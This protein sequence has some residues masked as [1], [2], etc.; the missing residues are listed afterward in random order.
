MKQVTCYQ[1]GQI[2]HWAKHCPNISQDVQKVMQIA[3]EREQPVDHGQFSAKSTS[4][5]FTYIEL[6][7]GIGGFRIALDKLGGHCVF[8]SEID[9][10]CVINYQKNFGDRPAGDITRIASDCIPDHDILVGGFPCQPF[11]NSGKLEGMNDTKGVLFREIARILKDKQPKGFILENVRGLLLHNDGDT[12]ATIRKELE[13][14]GYT[15]QWDII[16][17]VNLLPQERKRLYIIGIRRDPEESQRR[18]IFPTLPNLNRGVRDIMQQPSEKYPLS[19]DE[20]EKLTLT[21]HQLSKVLAQTYTQKF[22]EARFLCDLSL[23]SKTL[24]SSYSSYMV[25]SQFIPVYSGSQ[26]GRVQISYNDESM[27]WRRFSPREAARLQGFPESFYL[28]PQRSYHMIGNAVAPPIITMLATPL[29]QILGLLDE[30]KGSGWDVT[31]DLLLK[32]APNDGRRER[33]ETE[34]TCCS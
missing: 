3:R 32:A 7:A 4:A 20:L 1:C 8:A 16:D 18:Y 23:A 19:T 21:K 6:F 5:T 29:L 9:R 14:C 24:Q 31:I 15:L 30:L 12:F 26:C 28:C 34:L 10:F 22:P 2:N 11:S 33:L 17:A 27:K 25:G 13:A